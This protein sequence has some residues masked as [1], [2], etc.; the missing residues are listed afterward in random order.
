MVIFFHQKAQ[1]TVDNLGDHLLNIRLSMKKQSQRKKEKLEREVAKR[2]NALNN[3]YKIA[4]IARDFP[5]EIIEDAI[6]TEG[7]KE[8]IEELLRIKELTGAAKK[9]IRED[10]LQKY[11]KVHRNKIFE[12]LTPL[13]FCS[14][15]EEFMKALSYMKAYSK[16]RSEF[17]PVGEEP[18][19]EAISQKDKNYR[20]KR[21]HW[22]DAYF[23]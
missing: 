23:T 9:T 17:Y 11:S 3:L 12:I 14:Q 21:F 10:F 22:S 19:L 16:S 1:G 13:E 20:S 4:E 8:V 6:Y 18:S 15:N 2:L 7:S 5:K